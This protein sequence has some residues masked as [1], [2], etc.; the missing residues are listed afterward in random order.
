MRETLKPVNTHLISSRLRIHKIPVRSHPI[1]YGKSLRQRG[2]I[3]RTLKDHIQEVNK[4][5]TTAFERTHNG[6]PRPMLL[7]IGC[8][9]RAWGLPGR[10]ARVDFTARGSFRRGQA[11]NRG[12]D[13]PPPVSPRDFR[14]SKGARRGRCWPTSHDPRAR[15]LAFERQ[16]KCPISR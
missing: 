13:N 7:V 8:G 15:P 9:A 5:A 4:K 12:R 16:V 10:D 11:A 14:S 1:C 6:A 3:I 2:A